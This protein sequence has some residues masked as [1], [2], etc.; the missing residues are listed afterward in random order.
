MSWEDDE[1]EFDKPVFSS[2]EDEAVAPPKPVAPEPE[3]EKAKPK[4]KKAK[5]K[6]VYIGCLA[7][8]IC[9]VKLFARFLGRLIRL[10]FR[11]LGY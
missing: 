8:L 9:V 10:V 3:P 5:G 11:S 4:P 7:L 2:E 1:F 6:K